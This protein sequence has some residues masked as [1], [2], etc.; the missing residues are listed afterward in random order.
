[1]SEWKLFDGDVPH[2]STPEFH[3][4]RER[5]PHLEQP[6]HQPRLQ[7]AAELV[8]DAGLTYQRLAGERGTFSDLG[9]GDGGLLSVVQHAFRDAWGYDFQPSNRAGWAERGVAAYQK[10]VFGSDWDAVELGNV[11]ACTEVLEH[12]ADP[13]GVVKRLHASPDVHYVIASSPVNEGP[14]MHDECHAWAWDYSGY[15]AMFANAG[16]LVGDH[17]VVGNFQVIRGYKQ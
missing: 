15:E 10:D 6:H 14:D 3:K 16:W 4:D 13:H 12:L 7:T 5:A 8:L 9:C 1:M 2:V 11:V 17:R